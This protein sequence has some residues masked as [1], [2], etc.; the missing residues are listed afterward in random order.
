MNT[1]L[2]FR[3][4]YGYLTLFI[5]LS[6]STVEGGSCLHLNGCSGHGI[7]DTE[8]SRCNCYSGWGAT[9]DK[10]LYRAPD[11]SLRKYIY[12]EENNEA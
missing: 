11:C 1:L 9:E 4:M 12:N 2:S 7:C 3:Y 8:N 10:A 6:Y 5:I